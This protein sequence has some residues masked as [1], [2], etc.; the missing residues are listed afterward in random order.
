MALLKAEYN[1]FKID[2][3]EELEDVQKEQLTV[4]S[5]ELVKAINGENLTDRVFARILKN[6]TKSHQVLLDAVPGA[7]G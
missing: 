1:G 7:T 2:L 3:G 6:R 5:A 4:S